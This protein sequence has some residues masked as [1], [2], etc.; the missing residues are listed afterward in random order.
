MKKVVT[1]SLA[2]KSYQVEEAGYDALQNYLEKASKRLASN[3]DR[4]DILSDIEQSIADKCTTSLRPG[5]DVLSAA[6]VEEALLKVGPVENDGENEAEQGTVINDRARKLYM[7]P[8]EGKISGVCAGLAAYF[9]VD[10]TL[11]RLLF[12]LLLFLTQG[13]MILVY[14][15][16]VVAMPSAKTP[17][18]IAEAHG[19]PGT[20]KEIVEKV[21]LVAA[22]NDTAAKVGSVIA[23]VG[24]SI[25][26]V[27]IALLSVAFVAATI[28]WVWLLW[29]I[30]LGSLQLYDQLAVLNG[31]KQ[32][33]FATALYALVAVP[34]FAAVRGLNKVLHPESEHVSSMKTNVANSTIATV[35]VLA[36]VTVF[37]FGST[38][39]P[40]VRDYVSTHD[41]YVQIGE[42]T[43]CVDENKC[44]KKDVNML[45]PPRLF[46]ESGEPF[47]G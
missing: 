27:C 9:S 29:A 22:E 40:R 12:V 42:H 10:V 14:L 28:V 23:L 4:E 20:A 36:T 47:R 19:R 24:K 21:R 5:R 39:A 11:M 44:G 17:E 34:L 2:G 37:A 33:V 32:V 26:L 41:G 18:E 31:W 35:I 1:V 3:P 13:V 8:K 25:A 7:L 30:G 15:G 6:S 46:E 43:V 16:M 38:Y 45:E